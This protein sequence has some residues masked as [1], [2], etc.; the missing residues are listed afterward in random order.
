MG[1]NGSRGKDLDVIGAAMRE[2]ANLLPHFPRA[3]CLAVVQ[4]PWQLDIRR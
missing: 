4:I 2:L 3:V 1:E